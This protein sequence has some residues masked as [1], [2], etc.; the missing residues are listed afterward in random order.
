MRT[1]GVFIFVITKKQPAEPVAFIVLTYALS[2]A[3]E[4]KQEVQTYNLFGVPLT[5]H[6]TDFTFDFQIRFD[7][8]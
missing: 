7:L 3:P 1:T 6:L 2:T 4:R 5:I 8:L